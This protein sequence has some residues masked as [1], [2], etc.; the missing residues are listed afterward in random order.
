MK[1]RSTPDRR[2][3]GGFAA[4]LGCISAMILAPVAAF[5]EVDP[6]SAVSLLPTY[7]WRSGDQLAWAAPG[8][9]DS[10]W[11]ELPV[12]TFPTDAWKG[13]GWFRFRVRADPEARGVPV[14]L[15]IQQLGASE[16]FVDGRSVHNFGRVGRD[17]D[18]EVPDR[19]QDPR[20]IVLGLGAADG[21]G[22]SEHVIAV[23]YSS[24]LLQSPRWKGEEPYLRLRVGPLRPMVEGRVELVR[25]LSAHQ[26][27]L[28][29][30]SFAFVLT[31]L[32][33]VVF[34][35]RTGPNLYFVCMAAAA[36]AAIFTNFQI[37]VAAE[38]GSYLG[39][40]A[41]FH[42]AFVL[43]ALACLRFAYAL[44]RPQLPRQFWLF[45]AVG[46]PL[47]LW[48]LYQPFENQAGSYLFMLAIN[49]EIARVMFSSPRN[50]GGTEEDSEKS[51]GRIL[52]VGALPL[53][54]LS[55]YQL[56]ASLDVV[57]TLWQFVD[58]P[59]PYYCLVF[60]MASMSV[61]LAR[62]YARTQ[63][64]LERELRRVKV[65]SDE[66]LQQERRARQQEVERARLETENRRKDSE[67]EEARKLQLA[68]LPRTLP[69]PPGLS[70]VA[71]MRTATEVGGDYY[72]FL[73]PARG[74]LLAVL[75]D[76][77]GHGVQAG[78]LVATTQGILRGLGAAMAP[79]AL[80]GES[81]AALRRLGLRRRHMAL[82]VARFDAD[83]RRVELAAAGMPPVLVYR[84]GPRPEVEEIAFHSLPLGSQLG[85]TYERKTLD[86]RPGDRLVLMT[87]GLPETTDADGEPLGYGRV[88]EVVAQEGAGSADALL[89][90]L[91]AAAGAWSRGKAPDDDLT[92]LVIAV[93]SS[94]DP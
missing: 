67:L 9:D 45:T 58:F 33:L 63:G 41:L 72:D 7:R 5:G 80:L 14:G 94:E 89:D 19:T 42:A 12:G 70:V 32:L 36:G 34:R 78:T 76:A 28:A 55:P 83:G 77:T 53:V 86:L 81:S 82:A 23:R 62:D 38:S 3:R 87:D 75:G 74:P 65:L 21:E 27:L 91:L 37:F 46:V 50:R 43:M 16:V 59:A 51:G 15:R 66:A 79:E 2:R 90:G 40:S 88:A 17:P 35:A 8:L 4:V 64:R 48:G 85:D 6:G 20:P 31:H 49:V 10:G 1:P 22:P 13:I 11:K 92:L 56:L 25:K 71:H 60:L 54:V 44:I 29:G 39:L 57:P 24:Q 73:G 93:G 52:A 68:L 26:M 18:A 47:L 69:S 30:I 84:A 61:Y